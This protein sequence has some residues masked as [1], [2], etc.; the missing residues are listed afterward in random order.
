M[1]ERSFVVRTVKC[2][3]HFNRPERVKARLEKEEK[4][5]KEEKEKC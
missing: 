4:G 2:S 5:K 3:S 1:V